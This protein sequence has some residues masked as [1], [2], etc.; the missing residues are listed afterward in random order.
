LLAAATF[1]K[2]WEKGQGPICWHLWYL[3]IT[4]A[5]VSL[6]QTSHTANHRA[7]VGGDSKDMDTWRH[8]SLVLTVII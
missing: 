3:Y 8:D 7:I 1:W 2:Q 4:F 6:V 5:N